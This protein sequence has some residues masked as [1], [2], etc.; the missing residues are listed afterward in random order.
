[1]R[2]RHYPFVPRVPVLV[3][4]SVSSLQKKNTQL[5]NCLHDKSRTNIICRVFAFIFVPPASPARH[6]IDAVGLFGGLSGFMC[7][8]V[9]SQPIRSFIRESYC[10]VVAWQLGV[11]VCISIHGKNLQGG[12][13]M[14]GGILRYPDGKDV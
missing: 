14:G 8:L 5:V 3:V 7:S 12:W 1:M 4:C 2:V 11:L 10:L 9:S 6:L 13:Y